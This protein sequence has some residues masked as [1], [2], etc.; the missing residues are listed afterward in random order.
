M[1]YILILFLFF[2]MIGSVYSQP[3]EIDIEKKKEE[4]KLNGVDTIIIYYSYY[5]H[6][7]VFNNDFLECDKN[8]TNKT[9]KL[10]FWVKNGVFFKQKYDYKKVYNIERHKHSR[11]IQTILRN[12]NLISEC[13]IKPVEYIA[14][15]GAFIFYKE[16]IGGIS[17]TMITEFDFTF[18]KIK[19]NKIINHY[20]LRTKWLDKKKKKH[21]NN[22]KSNQKSILNK[23]KKLAE[24]EFQGSFF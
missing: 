18:G 23:I 21:N 9:P 3:A 17:E 2:Q 10:I 20:F 5:C 7:N 12:I 16:I 8:W 11:F 4:L 1:K 22:Y 14:Q 13:E 24:R 15:E 6:F 19:F